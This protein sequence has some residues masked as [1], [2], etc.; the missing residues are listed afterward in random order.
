M[1]ERNHNPHDSGSKDQKL[2]AVP[3]G[4]RAGKALPLCP[5]S[6]HPLHLLESTPFTP[7][8]LVH[9]QHPKHSSSVYHAFLS[10]MS[11]KPTDSTTDFSSGLW[12]DGINSSMRM[13]HLLFALKDFLDFSHSQNYL[14]YV[15][16]TVQKAK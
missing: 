7:A 15:V 10:I 13:A 12:L 11:N 14:N 9:K 5:T 6:S 16:C 4:S 8:G 1:A 2:L 3:F